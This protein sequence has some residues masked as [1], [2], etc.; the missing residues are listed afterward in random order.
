MTERVAIDETFED[1]FLTQACGVP[2]ELGH[3]TLDLWKKAEQKVGG[4]ADHTE[5]PAGTPQ[6][7]PF[8]AR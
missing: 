4:A 5:H 8:V 7:A 3:A 6:A 1:E 2:A